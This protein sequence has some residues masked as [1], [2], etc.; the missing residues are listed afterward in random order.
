[1]IQIPNGA[2]A[3]V[4]NYSEQVI[5]QYS[6]NPL[7]EA[8]P[9]IMSK[10][11]VIQNI[12][13][14]PYFNPEERMLDSHYRFHMIQQL[15]SYFQPLPIHIDLESRIS[16]LI[17]QG[18]INRNPL[19]P[20]Y[21]SS[22]VQGYEDIQKGKMSTAVHMSPSG[23]TIIG[24]SGMGKSSAIN[25]ILQMMP[26]VIC[27]SKYK[28]QN[29]NL[30]QTVFLKLECPPDGSIRGLIN[31][32]FVELDKLLGTKSMDKF[33]KN[34]R[35]SATSL[36][37]IVAQ[38]ARNSNL[39]LLVVD[40]IQNLSLA[41]SG[42][43]EQML[44]FFVALSNSIGLPVILIGTPK[45]IS[46]FSEFRQARRGSGQGDMMWEP[47][48]KDEQGW[49]LFLDGMWD[50]QWLRKPVPLS[51]ELSDA[52][53]EASCGITDI[54]VKTFI[55]SQ[56]RA[57][58][59]GTEE[60]TPGLI[61]NVAKESFKLIQ[62]MLYALRSG[63][64]L[65]IA[66]FGDI[67]P[68]NIEGFVSEEKSKLDLGN[69]LKNFQNAHKEQKINMERVKQEAIIRL[70]I[71]GMVEKD[72]TF[73]VNKLISSQ[74]QLRDLKEIV[75]EAYKMYLN[76]PQS[77]LRESQTIDEKNDLRKI[78]KAGKERGLSAYQS[79]KDAGYIVSDF[80]AG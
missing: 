50:Y 23:L 39:G 66:K 56:I 27:H 9:P 10:D 6:H 13:S 14:Y 58:T 65:K 21:S 2:M 20:H 73:C 80:V 76:I 8:L 41:K 26:Q 7:I 31:N 40:E 45:A 34:G 25:R 57:I 19:T 77:N 12:A 79:L 61:K 36:I 16:R 18:Y 11:Q 1:M 33:G 67:S 48:K 30:Y 75:Q 78:V 59:S 29:L 22:L 17:R 4:A 42:G 43:I 63:N 70:T 74:P 28:N 64:A 32:F 55:M 3:Q 62:P 44:S 24:V 5:S 46:L 60:L 51:V 69:M 38:I 53:Y 37:P 52:I 35:L 54:A 72:A 15:Y 71:L 47:M 68:I 49:K